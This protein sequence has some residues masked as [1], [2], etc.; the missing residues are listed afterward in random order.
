MFQHQHADNPT[1]A[2]SG[3]A[4]GCFRARLR[5]CRTSATC[6]CLTQSLGDKGDKHIRSPSCVGCLSPEAR[7]PGVPYRLAA[8]VRSIIHST[9]GEAGTS[10][11]FSVLC[12]VFC[13]ISVRNLSPARYLLPRIDVVYCLVSMFDCPVSTVHCLL[14]TLLYPMQ[15]PEAVSS[16][17]SPTVRVPWQLR[18]RAAR[19]VTEPWSRGTRPSSSHRG[20]Q[21]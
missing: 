18:S 8:G 14:S 12:D 15:T 17:C 6:L 4:Q 16:L 10:D 2:F 1:E 3:I 19:H 20:Y 21:L 13:V 5:T 7:V 11:V 9:G